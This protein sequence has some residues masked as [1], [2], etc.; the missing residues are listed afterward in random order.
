M[1]RA[2]LL[3]LLL[4]GLAGSTSCRSE[5]DA[6]QAVKVTDVVTGWLD[7]GIVDGQNKLVPTISLKVQ[8]SADRSLSYLQLDAVFRII[9]DTEEL[10]SMVIWATEGKEL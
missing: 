2:W 3:V 10:G 4:A 7:K 5:P 1:R 8:N 9:G 6:I